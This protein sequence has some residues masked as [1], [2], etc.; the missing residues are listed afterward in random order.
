MA[1]TDEMCLSF[2]NYYPRIP[3]LRCLSYPTETTTA[4]FYNGL[5]TEKQNELDSLSNLAD[6]SAILAAFTWDVDSIRALENAYRTD[7]N[8]NCGSIPNT[9]CDFF[10]D[11]ENGGRRTVAQAVAVLLAFVLVL[12]A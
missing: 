12:L 11:K 4:T 5:S 9:D 10:K 7:Y 8:P 1:T 6:P 3:L 2:L